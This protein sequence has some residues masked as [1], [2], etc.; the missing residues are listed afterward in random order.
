MVHENK[1]RNIGQI[2]QGG[3]QPVQPLLAQAAAVVARCYGIQT[4]QPDRIAL[5]RIADEAAGRPVGR[6][7]QVGMV[8]EGV[9]QPTLVVV[10]AGDDEKRHFERRQE[11]PGQVVAF[12]PAAVGDVAGQQH[13]VE[14]RNEIVQVVDH[15]AQRA[16]GVRRLVGQPPLG[17]QM[18]VGYLCDP[19][20]LKPRSG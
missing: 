2:P 14:R 17:L 15:F 16:G 11:F 20:G 12:Q 3:I 4:D 8:G 7:V 6:G 19:H 9:R 5:D 10:V 13:H 18:D 1:G